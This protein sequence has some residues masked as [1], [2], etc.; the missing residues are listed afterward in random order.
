MAKGGRTN[1]ADL[2]ASTGKNSPVDGEH[3]LAPATSNGAPAAPP[4][5]LPLDQLVANPRN[6]RQTMHVDDLASIAEIQQQP[7]LVITRA[8]YLGLWP[9]D[10]PQLGL[11]THVVINGCRRLLACATYGR[12]ALEIVIKDEVA[13]SKASLRAAAIRE[14]VE[15]ENL[16][17][18]EEA[19][20]VD[21]LV[22]DCGGVA[23]AAAAALGQSPQ[24]VS[25]RRS[26]LKLVPELQEKVRAGE[27]AFRTAR[28]LARVPSKE[29]LDRWLAQLDRDA[30]KKPKPERPK[31]PADGATHIAKA[32]MRWDVEV[33]TLASAATKYLGTN[34][35]AKLIEE[36]QRLAEKPT[37]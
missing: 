7:A 19:Q 5:Q 1:F 34:G 28:D 6:P 2:V 20:A 35:T 25:Q 16:D 9:E 22:A 33:P 36:L 27:L 14:N 30:E 15:R 18:I 31:P 37:S 23:T 13:A 29:Q 17:L 24:W 3:T 10:E 26:L 12:A 32:F 21:D 11:A 8:A 4:T